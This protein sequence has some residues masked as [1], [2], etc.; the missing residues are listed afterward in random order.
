MK[1]AV[2]F[3]G[4]EPRN[5]CEGVLLEV[6]S[7]CTCNCPSPLNLEADEDAALEQFLLGE[8]SVVSVNQA[9]ILA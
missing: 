6:S 5:L 1:G 4:Q 7:K 2:G 8:G 9:R 3:L